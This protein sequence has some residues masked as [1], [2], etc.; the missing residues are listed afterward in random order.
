M[1]EQSRRSTGQTTSRERRLIGAARRGEP[2]AQTRLLAVYEPL[3]RRIA[4]TLFL[5]GG[6]RDDLAQAARLG[7]IDAA[8]CWDPARGVPF[9]S[10]ARL[11]A[12]REARMALSAARARK[13]QILT[14]A[15]S[16]ERSAPSEEPD[17]AEESLRPAVAQIP[18]RRDDDPVAVTLA[19]EQLRAVIDR[20]GTL[21][22]L[23]RRAL[24]MAA[25]DCTH[26]EIA[27]ALGVSLRAVNNALQR[28]RHKLADPPTTGADA[29]RARSIEPSPADTGRQAA[30]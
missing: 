7:V 25:G 14:R 9:G 21:S 19:R 3:V 2:A 22:A 23:E 12:V 4:R 10:F 5:P 16:L 29:G 1:P 27:A 28:A 26:R 18:G 30:A 20:L 17:S 13:H 11:C 24:A 8:R 6:D 15:C